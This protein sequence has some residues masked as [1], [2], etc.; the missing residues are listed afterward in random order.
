MSQSNSPYTYLKKTKIL[1]AKREQEGKTG[2]V[3]DLLPVGW[4]DIRKRNRK[5]N[6]VEICTHCI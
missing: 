5:V 6:I 3:W 4:G 1:F 2:P